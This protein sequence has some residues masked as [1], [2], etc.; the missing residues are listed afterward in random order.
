MTRYLVLLLFVAVGL[1][2]DAQPLPDARFAGT[3]ALD[4]DRSRAVDPWRSLS[5]EIE[6]EGDAVV[7]ERNW[8]GSR[9]GGAFTDSVR[10]VPG[11]SVESDPMIQWGDERHLGA[12]IAGDRTKTVV[13]RWVD[14]GTT[15]ITESTF[16]VSIQQGEH[17][18]RVYTEYRLSP[19]GDRLDVLELRSTRPRPIHFVFSRAGA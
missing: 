11:Q 9:E 2:V 7:L 1:P 18:V 15:L 4:A 6:L 17:D 16:R 14:D 19:E 8:R 13:S 10:L 3:W 12:Y 5:V